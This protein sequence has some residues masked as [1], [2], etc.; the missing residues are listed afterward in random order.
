MSC[1]YEPPKPNLDCDCWQPSA[2]TV[3]ISGTGDTPTQF[4][5]QKIDGDWWLC[6]SLGTPIQKMSD[7]EVTSLWAPIPALPPPEAN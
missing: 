4:I 5:I 7:E 1:D 3:T 2:Y 6:R